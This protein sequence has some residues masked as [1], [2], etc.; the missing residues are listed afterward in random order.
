MDFR[1]NHLAS[2]HWL[3]L[4]A[5]AALLIALGL[6]ARQRALQR[7]ASV[8]LLGHLIPASSLAR[9]VARAVLLLLAM[10]ALVAAMIDPRW[11]VRYEDVKR[12]GMDILF[13]VDVSR[14]MLA[15]D[16]KPN[17]L[18]RAK[19]LVGDVVEELAGDRVGLISFA[20]VAAMRCPLT[21]DYGAFRLSLNDLTTESS[22]KGGSLL[23]AAL[24]LAGESFTDDAKDYKTVIV[25]SDGEDQGSYPEEAAK[26]LFEDKGI[27][28]FT[29]GIGDPSD[30]A[31]IPINNNTRKTY[32]THDGQEVWTKMHPETLQAVALNAG[33]AYIPAPTGVADLAAVYHRYIAPS[34]SREFETSRIKVYDPQYQWFAGLA[35]GLLVIEMWLSERRP[36]RAKATTNGEVY[37]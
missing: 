7:F 33:G 31:R 8:P 26:K 18:D 14:S 15:E 19:L 29:V 30:G 36:M 28:V 34:E 27:K 5:A 17:R 32:L 21:V 3:W 1:F 2:L 23:G 35:L 11:G 20:G 16:V 4:V 22:A 6:A 13:I 10:I 25:L 9:K 24:S 12:R 37:A